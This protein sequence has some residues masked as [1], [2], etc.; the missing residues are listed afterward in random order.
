[1]QVDVVTEIVSGYDVAG[2]QFDYL[3]Y[4]WNNVCYCGRCR[5]AFEQMI[6]RKVSSWPGDAADGPLYE[7]FLQF[8]RRQI[9]TLVAEL[10][11]TAK[12]IDPGI[13]VSAA[14]FINWESH[15]DTFGQDWKTWVDRGWVDF[16]CPMDYT[17][18]LETFRGY[19]RRQDGWVD[20]Q[21][22]MFVGIGVN[23]DNCRF[24]DP[25][26]ALRQVEIARAEGA[27][28]WVIFNYCPTFVERILPVM[29]LGVTRTP[30]EYSITPGPG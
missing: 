7:Q 27:D 5:A 2:I 30:T 1:M 19:V 14:V 23:A 22:P 12:A 29:S 21:R 8:R 28:G 10:Y 9:N 4:P 17:D 16:V 3:R 18:D 20:G 15:R 13:E 24:A 25:W 6:G 26:I 11:G